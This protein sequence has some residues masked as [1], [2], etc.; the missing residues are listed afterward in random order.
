MIFTSEQIKSV[1]LPA[2]ASK[3]DTF[4]NFLVAGMIEYTIKGNFVEAAFLA[5]LLHESGEFRYVKELASGQAY[6]GRK[7]LGNVYE[8]DGVRFKGRGL[9]QITGRS[10]YTRLG[11]DMCNDPDKFI[12][13]PELLEVPEYAAKSACWFWYSRGLNGVKD[14]KKITRLINGGYNGLEQRIKYFDKLTAIENA[15]NNAKH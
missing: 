11:K 7:D 6:E 3:V 2:N 12:N 4:Y 8:G 13:N 9:I 5:Q 15:T 14:F 10:N 1:V